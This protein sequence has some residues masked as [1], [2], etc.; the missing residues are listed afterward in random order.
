[1]LHMDSAD[2]NI[3]SKEETFGIDD[4]LC[5]SYLLTQGIELT[6]IIRDSPHHYIF[7]LSDRQRCQEL[8]QE[9]LNGATAPA[10][11]LFS[12]REMLISEI[13]SRE[14]DGDKKYGK[15]Y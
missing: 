3:Y 4:I 14:R 7:F 10:R 8:K 15:D 6:D 2:K 12:L 5:A 9:Y 1:M 11:E 13:K